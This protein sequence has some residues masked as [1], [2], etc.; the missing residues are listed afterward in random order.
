MILFRHR[1]GDSMI[2]RMSKNMSSFFITKGIIP[3]DDRDV[4]VYSFE[5]LLSTLVSLCAVAVIAAISN[6]V[7]QMFLFFLG[8]V[9][10]RLIAGGFHAKNH[11]RC[12]I[13]LLFVC[14]AFLLILYYIP[15]NYIIPAILAAS[16]LSLL[17]TFL[18]APSEDKNK[19]ATDEETRRFKRKSRFATIIYTVSVILALI[20]VPDKVYA[21]SLALGV[22][23][24]GVSLLA[25]YVKHTITNR[26]NALAERGEQ[27]EEI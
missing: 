24:V 18:F 7:V 23:T 27:N 6:T 22:F 19:P 2:A 21:L 13:I 15:A 25:N 9:P 1:G 4:Y 5:I 20:L 10:L 26:N 3:D 11:F 14:A 16:S 8:F 12:F 17:L